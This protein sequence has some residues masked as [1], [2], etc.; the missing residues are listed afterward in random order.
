MC[1]W[2]KLQRRKQ[3]E[4]HNSVIMGAL[5]KGDSGLRPWAS[6]GEPSSPRDPHPHIIHTNELTQFPDL[7]IARRKT[8]YLGTRN[9]KD[10][11]TRKTRQ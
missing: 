10:L 7:Q 11:I 4:F 1:I 5:T 8:Y 3:P 9:G 6:P 2:Q